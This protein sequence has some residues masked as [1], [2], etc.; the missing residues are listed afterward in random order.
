MPLGKGANVDEY[1][2]A[3]KYID[4]AATIVDSFRYQRCEECGYD[5]DKHSI[6]PD[7]LGN[8]HC[9]CLL[10]SIWDEEQCNNPAHAECGV[11][12]VWVDGKHAHENSDGRCWHFDNEDE[13]EEGYERADGPNK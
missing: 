4:E 1:D 7:I 3:T 11:T 10:P 6:G 5:L 13:D 12:V 9:Y 2:L 8:A